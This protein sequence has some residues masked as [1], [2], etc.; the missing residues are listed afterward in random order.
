MVPAWQEFYMEL[1]PARRAQLLQKNLTEEEDDG[2]NAY[3]N[4]LFSLRYMEEGKPEP[5]VD[6]WLWACVNFVQVYSSSRLLKR[7][8]KREVCQFLEKSGYR[9]AAG[10]TLEAALYWE[11]RNAAKRYFKTCTGTEYRRVLF[12]LLSPGEADQRKHMCEDVWKMTTGLERRFGMTQE[13]ALWT[14]AVHDEYYLTDPRAQE[15]LQEMSRS[16]EHG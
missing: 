6:R 7:G 4:R 16:M 2:A 14:K 11:I 10:E 15:R 12:G 1:E 13:L 8:G 3:R 5:S 9:E